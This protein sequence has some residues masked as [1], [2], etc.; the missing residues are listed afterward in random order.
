M[1]NKKIKSVMGTLTAEK[2]TGYVRS[3]KWE[4]AKIGVMAAVMLLPET[5]AFAQSVDATE[6]S[7]FDALQKPMTNLQKFLTGPV[8]KA[9][10]TI[11][12]AA[13]CTSWALNVENQITK[14]ALRAAMGGG[15]ALGAAGL[16]NGITGFTF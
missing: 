6:V 5:S 9:G 8:P 12:A 16:I 10:V 1:F 2:I 14:F 7:G 13:G 15:G 11:A 3:H 4:L